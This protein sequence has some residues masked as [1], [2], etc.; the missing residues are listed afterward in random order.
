ML[1]EQLANS[2]L[3]L[4]LKQGLLQI[5]AI[6]IG[7]AASGGNVAG[8]AAAQNATANNYLTHVQWTDLKKALDDCKKSGSDCKEV[9]AAYQKLN[10]ANDNYLEAACKQPNSPDCTRLVAEATQARNDADLMGVTALG[11]GSNG[12]SDLIINRVQ[13]QRNLEAAQAACDADPAKCAFLPPGVGSVVKI[14][15]GGIQVAAG[16]S[17]CSTTGLG[18]VIG[19]PLAI[20]GA[21]EAIEGST[22]LYNQAKGTGSVGFNPARAGLNIAFPAQGDLIYDT[23]YLLISGLSLTAPVPLKVPVWEGGSTSALGPLDRTTSMFGSTVPKWQNPTINPV[24]GGVLLTQPATQIMSVGTNAAKV[25]PV[26]NDVKSQ[27]KK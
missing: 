17:I 5:A 10:V 14:V 12:R 11:A 24:T 20:Y 26:V 7:T 13:S 4:E 19:A 27:D 2:A 22:A 15:G 25:P 21:S 23:T 3:P 18:C 6:A 1:G 16:A 9:K 8:A